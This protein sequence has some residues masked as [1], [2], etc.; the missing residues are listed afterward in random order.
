MR[1]PRI[2]LVALTMRPILPAAGATCPSGTRAL[3]LGP[4]V[5]GHPGRAIPSGFGRQRRRAE[6]ER[7]LHFESWPDRGPD[8]G[9][10]KRGGQAPQW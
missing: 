4:G 6:P 5:L 7:E 1:T 2:P 10:F 3:S 9:S 8:R